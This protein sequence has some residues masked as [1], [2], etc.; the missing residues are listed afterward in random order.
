MVYLFFLFSLVS[1]FLFISPK[2]FHAPFQKGVF[3]FLFVLTI[4]HY[5][6]EKKSKEESLIF[7]VISE[8]QITILPYLL[9][10][11][12]IVFLLS[13]TYHGFHLT[14]AFADAFLFQDA[15][16]I[17]ISDILL[18]IAKG[19]GF[20]SAYY[21]ESGQGSYLPHHFAPGMFIL[22]PFVSFIPNR[23]GLAVGVFFVYQ[24]GTILWLLWAY[25]I[26]KKNPKEL[27]IKFIVF[28]VLL[29]NQ[30]YLYRLGS[31][32]HFE[33]L[34]LLFGFFFFYTW[35]LRT[36]SENSPSHIRW[37]HYGILALSL[38]LYLIQKEDIGIYLLLFFLPVL[39]RFL[40]QNRILKKQ[41]HKSQKDNQIYQ[42]QK[43]PPYTLVFIVTILWLSFVFFV[44]PMFNGSSTSISWTKVLRQEYHVAF[45]QV[46]GFQKS[47]Q[48][49]MELM[50]SGGLGIFQMIPEVLGI[51][52]IYATHLFSTRPWH[53]EVYTYYSYSLIPFVL[54]AGILWI[55]SEKKISTSFA[56]LILTCLFWKNSL[57]HNFPLDTK[58]ESPYANSEIREEIQSDLKETNALLLGEDKEAEKFLQKIQTAGSVGRIQYQTKNSPQTTNPHPTLN[59]IEN[60]KKIFVFAQYN[61]SFFVTDKIKTYPIE[62][63]KNATSICKMANL[64]YVVLAPEFTDEVLWPKSRVLVYRKQLE[65]QNGNFVWKGKQIEVWKL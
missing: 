34:V 44:Y 26:T 3:L 31:S 33:V 16:Y 17:G 7:G 41:I 29:T 22:S 61:L 28:W 35:E 8:K 36:K 46:T 5:W 52:L 49:F 53:H 9:C 59:T 14:K 32:F 58:I 57:D 42:D 4:T 39:I 54:Y 27:G 62:Q 15:D 43:F 45:K 21:S 50:V 10:L 38:V 20:S 11:S 13:S 48:I 56:L 65:D 25:R 64:C 2:H 19:D 55:Q 51:G 47:F 60:N 6:K 63:I 40:Y 1:P 23:W 24:L 12:C 30:L 18:S 37:I